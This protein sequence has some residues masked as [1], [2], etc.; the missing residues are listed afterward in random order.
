M[1]GNHAFRILLKYPRWTSASNMF[2]TNNVPTFHALLTLWGPEDVNQRPGLQRPQCQDVNLRPPLPPPLAAQP[3]LADPNMYTFY[4]SV[5]LRASY[6]NILGSLLSRARV[7][8]RRYVLRPF[9]PSLSPERTTLYGA[10][11]AANVW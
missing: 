7:H 6:E 1:V 8:A 2:V 10:R 9:R 4:C 5:R 3:R 11:S